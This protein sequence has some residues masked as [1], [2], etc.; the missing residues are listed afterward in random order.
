MISPSEKVRILPKQEFSAIFDKINQMKNMGLDVINLSQGNP[1]M[2]TP[3]HIVEEIKQA[4]GVST[5]HRYPPFRGYSFLKTAICDFYKKEYD[6]EVDPE[7]EIAIFNGGKTAIYVICQ[8]FLNENDVVLTPNPGYPEYIPDILMSN[9]IPYHFNLDVQNNYLPTYSSF[10]AAEVAKAMFLNYPNNP[11]GATA[12]TQFFNETVNFAEKNN[13]GIIHD[14]AYAAF[15]FNGHKPVSF[16]QSKNAKKVGI[17]L[18]TLSKTYNMAGWRIAFAVGNEQMIQAIHSFQDH[19]FVSVFG[20]VQKAAAAALQG[21]QTCVSSLN[22][23]YETRASYF[24]KEC[25]KR[26]GWNIEKP[27]GTFYVWAPVPHGYDSIS[28][29]SH[30]LEKAHVAVTPGAIFGDKGNPF[31]RISMVADI[32]RLEQFIERLEKLDL[33]FEL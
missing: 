14:F 15:G 7:K 17:E 9:A 11:T 27:K 4:V 1:D 32:K 12:N 21:D 23:L 26:L 13:V 19:V 24:V 5:F 28:F 3:P 18:Y 6:V 29:T 22:Q 20:G 16:L 2:P 10:D 31:I 25:K 30:L 8:A 33:R